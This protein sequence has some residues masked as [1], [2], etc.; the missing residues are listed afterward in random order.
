MWGGGG[1]GGGGT[2]L[3]QSKETCIIRLVCMSLGTYIV[4]MYTQSITYLSRVSLL[5]LAFLFYQQ[6]TN[7]HSAA[8]ISD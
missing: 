3:L 7:Y 4:C 8:G 6:W 2:E 5:S 1:G